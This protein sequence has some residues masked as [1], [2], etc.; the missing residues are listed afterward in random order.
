MLED[1]MVELHPCALSSKQIEQWLVLNEIVP[2]NK[3]S[4]STEHLM[5]QL[6]M[7]IYGFYERFVQ[8]QKDW[9]GENH[10]ARE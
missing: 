10:K 2:G 6:A 7:S 9:E 4:G 5:A 1:S 3:Q 8:D